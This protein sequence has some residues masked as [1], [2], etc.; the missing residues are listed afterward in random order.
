MTQYQRIENISLSYRCFSNPNCS[1]HRA[2]VLNRPQHISIYLLSS[3][4][5]GA[6]YLDPGKKSFGCPEEL[7]AVLLQHSQITGIN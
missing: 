1:K 7:A 6:K 3:L 5:C 2:A 4:R